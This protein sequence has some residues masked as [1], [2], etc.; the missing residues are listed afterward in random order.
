MKVICNTFEIE[1]LNCSIANSYY[2]ISFC[3]KLK[4]EMTDTDFCFSF[5]TKLNKRDLQYISDNFCDLINNNISCFGFKSCDKTLSFHFELKSDGVISQFEI[6]KFSSVNTYY[7]YSINMKTDIIFIEKLYDMFNYIKMHGFTN[8]TDCKFKNSAPLLIEIFKNIE[9]NN[10]SLRLQFS[11]NRIVRKN[12][13][14]QED[15]DYLKS[16]I[17][18]LLAKKILYFN[19]ESDNLF[20]SIT[21]FGSDFMVDGEISD[22]TFPLSNKLKMS[23]GYPI[24]RDAIYKIINDQG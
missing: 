13:L 1:L 20:L 2:N 8:K 3:I 24:E 16:Q 7:T 19:I 5:I 18:M 17:S 21:S 6:W 22:F 14:Q 11:E 15:I 12:C 4:N 10:Y 23:G 9:S